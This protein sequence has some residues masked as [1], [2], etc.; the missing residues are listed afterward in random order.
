MI[1]WW[2]RRGWCT[3]RLWGS[4][5]HYF[6]ASEL[7]QIC[8]CSLLRNYWIHLQR[9]AGPWWDLAVPSVLLA[10]PSALA[11]LLCW[12]QTGCESRPLPGQGWAARQ[13]HVETSLLVNCYFNLNYSCANAVIFEMAF[14][15]GLCEG[16]SGIVKVHYE[17]ILFMGFSVL[18]L[19]R[20]KGFLLVLRV[21]CTLF[22]EKRVI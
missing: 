6:L 8:T 7:L 22:L 11:T 16:V 1:S 5:K 2:E 18:S 19:N 14:R 15:R 17:F 20:R 9:P 21:F 13:Q 4:V 3:S 12:A 10:V